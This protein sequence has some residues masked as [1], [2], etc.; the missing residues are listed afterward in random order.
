MKMKY[1]GAALIATMLTI[2][3]QAKDIINF[4]GVEKENKHKDRFIELSASCE[5]ATKS[6]DLDIN[7]VRAK[8]LNGGDMW[9]DLSSAKYEVPKVVDA[10]SVRKN[11]LFAGALWIGGKIGQDLHIAAMTYR[12]SG[13]DF[14]PGPLDKSTAS[15]DQIRCENYDRVWKIERTELE[16]FE[17]SGF[18]DVT[19]DISEWPAG[20]SRVSMVG[21]EDPSMAPFFDNPNSAIGIYDPFNGDYPVLDD[22]R[23][24]NKNGVSKQP[25]QMIWMVY[26]DRGNIHTETNGDPIGIELRTTAFA[27]ATNDEVN[28]MTFYTTTVINRGFNVVDDA[29]FGQWV[30]ADLG[31]FSDD[32]V[33]CDVERSLGYCYNGDN[34]DE[35]ISGYGLNPPSVGVDYFEGPIDQNGNE[36]GLSHFMY[37][38]NDFNPITGNPQLAIHY[39]N[40]LQG[41]WKNG[42]KVTYGGDGNG[43]N[44]GATNDTCNY[45]FPGDTDPDFSDEW[46]ERTAGNSPADR[47]FVQSSGPFRLLPGAVNKVT[48]ACVWART[49]SGGATGSLDLLRLASDKAQILFNNGFDLIDGPDAP[50]VEVQELENELVFQFL[51]VNDEDVERYIDTT[52]N[53][54]GDELVYGFQGYLVYQLKDGTVNTG[55]LDNPDRARLVFQCDVKD[56]VT[57]LVNREIDPVI[58]QKVPEL[59]VN[60]SDAGLVH[61]FSIKNDLFATGSNQSLVN[62][63]TY[64]Y[65]VLS[66]ANLIN[67][68]NQEEDIQFLGGRKNIQVYRAIP[69]KVESEKGGL[70]LNGSYGDGP[71]ITRLEGRGNGGN[72]LE[73]TKE[74]IDEILANGNMENPV[75]MGGSGPIKV[76]VV[77]PLKVPN[78]EFELYMVERDTSTPNANGVLDSISD[79]SHWILVNKTSGDTVYSDTTIVTAYEVIQGVDRNGKVL[80]TNTLADWGLSITVENVIGPGSFY[81]D[82]EHGILDV[83]VEYEDNARQWLTALIDIDGVPSRNWIRAGNVNNSDAMVDDFNRSTVHWDKDGVFERMWDGRVAPYA[84]AARATLDSRGRN[85]FGP[86]SIQSQ[87]LDNRL[88]DLASVDVV[89]TPDRSKW[90]QCIVLEGGDDENK[91]LNEGQMSKMNMRYHNSL[92]KDYTVNTGEIGRG[93]FPGYAVN[94]ET[95]ER[96]NMAFS[97]DSYLPNENGADMIWNPTD[98]YNLG[99]GT[100]PS[101]GGKH[102]IYIMQGSDGRGAPNGLWEGTMYDG[103]ESY[104]QK[105]AVSPGGTPSGFKKRDVLS[106]CMW[107]IPTILAPGYSMDDGVPLTEV[108]IKIRME[109]PY[110]P[111]SS[112]QTA[113]NGGL[114]M[115]SFSTEDIIPEFSTENGIAAM[116]NVNI[117][118][119]PYYGYSK[120]ES[121]KIDNRVRI[122]NLPVKCQ[123]SIYTLDGTL[124]KRIDKDNESTYVDWLLKND[125]D[126]PIASGLYLVHVDGFELGEKILKWFGAMKRIDLDSF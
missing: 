35:G 118:P 80:T 62:Y 113:R 49:T 19:R 11:S 58:G 67:D 15:T 90:T 61:T 66:Y 120:Y 124:V 30:D 48:V 31:N 4:K 50:D 115:Y 106:Q 99:S 3:V 33:G 122:T 81:R 38:N 1:I 89:I 54:D 84:Y 52:K 126:V 72:V 125:A 98:N 78:A 23:P 36:L 7:N 92:N 55:D 53:V 114:P 93:W 43:N 119:N 63:T 74:T 85:S 27:F 70:V 69:H 95:G 104:R 64:Y 116:E 111:Y 105:M 68:P 123:I 60:G 110:A 76:K 45:M 112:G 56:G 103:G 5:A 77:D 2:N 88:K 46:T 13:S 12:Q 86:A 17:E 102:Y 121:N 59:M 108:T 8:I 6:A 91:D 117:V 97:E 47:R 39:Y 100:Y 25:D 9:W 21:N 24:A 109:K 28:N 73:F 40:Y 65:L 10:T 34:E 51:N 37:Y 71:Q 82:P 107:V 101:Y 41:R 44:G 87:V 42:S 16:D 83:T 96:L 22:E 75:Y 29:Y 79:N 57:G 14:W 20:P 32:Y 94:L 18:V 26:N